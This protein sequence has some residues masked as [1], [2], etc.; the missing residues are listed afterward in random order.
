M[1][2]IKCPWQECTYFVCVGVV[3][4]CLLGWS[5]NVHTCMYAHI[6]TNIKQPHKVFTLPTTT[7]TPVYHIIYTG[8]QRSHTPQTT[9][10]LEHYNIHFHLLLQCET[11]HTIRVSNIYFGKIDNLTQT[12]NKLNYL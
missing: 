9:P 1:N 4:V 2:V 5:T 3:V 11:M 10:P 12:G 6:Q 8:E 7:Y